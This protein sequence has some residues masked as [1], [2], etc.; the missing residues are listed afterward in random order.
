MNDNTTIFQR[1]DAAVAVDWQS[2]TSCYEELC[3]I[4]GR[5]APSA[6]DLEV[7]KSVY[8]ASSSALLDH[9][10]DKAFWRA[11]SAPTGGGKTTATLALAAAY[12]RQGGSVLFLAFTNRDCDEVFRSLKLLLKESVAIRTTDHDQEKLDADPEGY[13][14][15]TEDQRGYT[16]STARR[17]SP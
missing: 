7:A 9:K 8:N 2:F 10:E 1:N 14:K 11:V 3:G 12:V 13:L 15:S 4:Q 16:P 17:P 5:S 6:F